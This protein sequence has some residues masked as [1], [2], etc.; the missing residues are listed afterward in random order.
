MYSMEKEILEKVERIKINNDTLLELDRFLHN[1]SYKL[2]K[3]RLEELEQK[4]TPLVENLLDRICD[5]DV[6]DEIN[7]EKNRLINSSEDVAILITPHRNLFSDIP[8][9]YPDSKKIKKDSELYKFRSL[10]DSAGAKHCSYFK[11]ALS[12][13]KRYPVKLKSLKDGNGSIT[14]FSVNFSILVQKDLIKKDDPVL[15]NLKELFLKYIETQYL[16]EKY[17]NL[18]YGLPNVFGDWNIST[19][20]KKPSSWK[21]I[22][23]VNEELFNRFL[24]YMIEKDSKELTFVNNLKDKAEDLISFLDLD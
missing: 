2:Y 3:D 24:E 15:G 5:K 11:V 16:S 9:I 18:Y 6:L 10:L 23:E 19:E 8:G 17:Y 1:E 7:V 4:M 20:T 21:H 12:F 13:S 14:I 22:K